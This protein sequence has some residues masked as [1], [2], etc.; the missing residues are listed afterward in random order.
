MTCNSLIQR[1]NFYLTNT[2]MSIKFLDMLFNFLRNM[3]MLKLHL[4]NNIQF[5][6]ATCNYLFKLTTIFML[7]KFLNILFNSL[8]IIFMLLLVQSE[9][10]PSQ[11]EF[12]AFWVQLL[13]SEGE[14]TEFPP[15]PQSPCH[16]TRGYVYKL[17]SLL[18]MII[19]I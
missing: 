8:K 5:S 18:I 14:G 10:N 7:I 15:P 9:N 16:S 12:M 11:E 4:W 2:V 13:L 6:Y 19:W 1:V 17:E 3:Y